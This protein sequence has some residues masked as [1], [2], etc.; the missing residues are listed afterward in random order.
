MLAPNK[1]LESGAFLLLWL[2]MTVLGWAIHWSPFL[3]D[4]NWMLDAVSPTSKPI[5]PHFMFVAAILLASI[6]AGIVAT[7]EWLSM[8]P[9][10]ALA[11]RWF[12]A[13]FVGIALGWSIGLILHFQGFYNFRQW[14]GSSYAE[15][16]DRELLLQATILIAMLAGSV[17][18]LIVGVCQALA[19]RDQITSWILWV[20]ITTL[21]WALGGSVYWLVYSFM[22]GPLCSRLNCEDQP[23]GPNYPTS[24][25]VSWFVGGLVVGWTTALAKWLLFSHSPNKQVDAAEQQSL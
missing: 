11:G 25:L 20:V 23:V 8:L 4:Y 14:I 19:A 9:R 5:L 18:G 2:T 24:V 16:I 12:R 3:G 1:R 22:G 17:V 15:E 6:S 21:A 13:T 10:G 7:G